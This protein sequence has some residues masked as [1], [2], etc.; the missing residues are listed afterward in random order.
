M[1]VFRTRLAFQNWRKSLKINQT[2]GFVPTM[3]ALH[4]GHIS[5]VR[6]AEKE[7]DLVVVSIFVN[8]T[9]FGPKEDF[10]KYPRR[11]KE[12][13][14]LLRDSG[15]DAVFLP[16]SVHEVY[17]FGAETKVIARPSLTTML[18][19]RFRP[20]HFDGV[21][22]VVLKLFQ[23]AQSHRA[24]FGE[25]DYQQLQVIK[26]MASDFFLDLKVVACPTQREASGLARSSR[27]QYLS[28]EAR[29]RAGFIYQTLN[30]VK[31]TSEAARALKKK[32]FKVQY[33][34]DWDLDLSSQK[35]KGLRRRLFA[36][37]FNGVRLIDNIQ[38][39]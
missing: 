3:G 19:G 35:T 26:A 29:D 33:L 38:K 21:V 15:V 4:E 17:G 5:L 12:D 28:K 30:R 11:E 24:Y 13:L 9:Q 37:F 32:G 27:N 20:G 18:E 1:K 2:I 8:P 36:G 34:E 23:I 14:Q 16:R 39:K 22:T 31:S 6:R 25:K 7:N 10:K